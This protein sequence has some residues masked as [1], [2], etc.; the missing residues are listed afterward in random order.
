MHRHRCKAI[1][2]L[3]H[4]SADAAVAVVAEVIGTWF[5][6]QTFAETN[7]YLTAVHKHYWNSCVVDRTRKFDLSTCL[8]RVEVA[9]LT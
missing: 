1:N 8:A 2:F 3:L 9:T 5:D 6:L 7:L 4:H